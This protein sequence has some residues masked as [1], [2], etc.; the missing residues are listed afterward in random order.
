MTDSVIYADQVVELDKT[1]AAVDIETL[2]LSLNAVVYEIGIVCTNFLPMPGTKWGTKDLAALEALAAG[3]KG[4]LIFEIRKI[5]ISIEEQVRDGR[6]TDQDTLNFHKKVFEKR[7]L[8]ADKEFE[9]HRLNALT[10]EQARTMLGR[11]FAEHTPEEVWFN[12]TSFDVPRITNVLYNG[13]PKSVPWN[14]RSEY[15]VFTAKQEYRNAL[16]EGAKD[17]TKFQS[18]NDHHDS[19]GDCLYNLAIVSA[20]RFG[21]RASKMGGLT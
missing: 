18:D 15:D 9:K 12:H 19:V 20:C 11:F 3:S 8:D 6:V 4:D 7:G 16:D 5:L 10:L 13:E 2:S 21:E 17:F 14:Y 1:I